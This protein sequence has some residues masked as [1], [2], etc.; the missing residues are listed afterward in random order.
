MS[1]RG[2]ATACLTVAVGAACDRD[3]PPAPA[4]SSSA[5]TASVMPPAAGPLATAPGC[6]LAIR[7]GTSLGP[8][9]LGATRA[10][11]ENLGVPI[12]S[13][14]K[15]DQTEFL[16]VGPIQVELCGGKV[17]DTWLDDLRKAPDCVT[18]DG[19]KIRLDI[20]REKF[21]ALFLDCRTLPPRIGGAFVECAK[22]GVR[23]GHGLGEFIQVRVAPEG[24]KLDTTCAMILDDGGHV[25]IDAAV[26]AKLLQRTLDLD[27]LAQHWHRNEPGRDPLQVVANAVVKDEPPLTMFGSPVV[28]E[29]RAKLDAK[30]L[31]YFLFTKLESS[32]TKT[33]IR[34]RFPAEGVVGYVVFVKR[35]DEWSLEKKHVA[36]Q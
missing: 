11:L 9:R 25:P 7:P 22:G 3:K 36:E 2:V 16:E 32:A 21:E 14:S 10:E 23:V 26:R 29:R 17:V 15:Q 8:V 30:N 34:F 33:T 27:L 31:P 12:K 19:K 1:F 24:S 20:E 6:P 28:F 5:P 35:G 4:A 13:T 18:V